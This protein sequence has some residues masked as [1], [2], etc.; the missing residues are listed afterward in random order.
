MSLSTLKFVQLQASEHVESVKAVANA[1]TFYATDMEISWPNISLPNF[2]RRVNESTSIAQFGAFKIAYGPLVSRTKRSEWEAF[3]Q[4]ETQGTVPSSILGFQSELGTFEPIPD[5]SS[6]KKEVK[7]LYAPLWQHAPM[8]QGGVSDVNFDLLSHP[9]FSEAIVSMLET[10][11]VVFSPVTTFAELS[12]FTDYSILDDKDSPQTI[13]L[14]PIHS[15]VDDKSIAGIA[16]SAISWDTL[17]SS[18]PNIFELQSVVVIRDSCG[19]VFTY[20]VNEEGPVFLG[21]GDHH[22][23]SYDHLEQSG[24]LVSVLDDA[25][26]D[27]VVSTNQCQYRVS[28]FPSSSLEESYKTN[29]R[30]ALTLY[31]VLGFVAVAVAF[32]LYDYFLQRRYWILARSAHRTDEIVA[33]FFP[34]TVRDRILDN[35]AHHDSKHDA[36]GKPIA[37]RVQLK[38]YLDDEEYDFS[39]A[40]HFVNSKPIADLFPDVTVMFA[41]I[42]GFTAWSSVR[43]PSQVFM[44][45]EH[46]YA[47]FDE[48]ARRRGVFKVETVGDCYVA[49]CGLPDPNPRHAVTMAR[50][51]R[52]CLHR[53]NDLTTHLEV[54]LGPDTGELELRVGLHSGPVTAGVL[55]GEK[56]RFQLFGDTMNTTSRIESTGQPNRIHISSDTADL[57]RKAGKEYWIK[58]REKTVEAKGKGIMSTYWL[59]SSPRTGTSVHSKDSDLDQDVPVSEVNSSIYTNNQNSKEDRLVSYISDVFLRLLREL[60]NRRD[61]LDRDN[62][63]RR[64]ANTEEILEHLESS[65]SREGT[66]VLD[67]VQDI[68]E[69]PNFNAI[70]DK[71]QKDPDS[72]VL[73]QKII[74]QVHHYVGT[75]AALYRK[76]AFHNFEHAAHVTMSTV[77]LL[78]RIVAPD[79]SASSGA[80]KSLHDHTYGIT[81][82]PLTRFA[83]VFSALI[84]DVDHLGIPNSQLIEENQVIAD[85][86]KNRSV[87]EQN[88]VDL[89]W[90]LL[91]R[92][93]YKDFRRTIY[94]TP[95][96]YDRFR[97]LVV[98]AVLATDI[99]DKELK[100]LRNGRW[101]KAFSDGP[102]KVKE[103]EKSSINRKATI[104]IEHL[105]QASDVSHTMQHWHVFTKWN[106]RLFHEMYTAYKQGRAVK[107][108]SEF[109][110]TGEMG[111]FD[112][113]IIPLAN[114]LKTCGVFGVS[115]DEYLTYA[116]KNRK[117]W[118]ARGREYVA[119]YLESYN[120]QVAAASNTEYLEMKSSSPKKSKT[121]F[122]TYGSSK[123]KEIA[124]VSSRKILEAQRSLEQ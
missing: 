26:I 72:V 15:R 73:P 34:K 62:P 10:G 67:E 24:D 105:I 21:T 61:A 107:D 59:E 17:F 56:A 37:P 11:R 39:H 86:Y 117:E 41:D 14:Q 53:M 122:N 99:M 30:I 91:M 68:I 63:N 71:Y 6:N 114:K 46:V 58:A 103:S 88:S 98:N 31:V 38:S 113:Y 74:S 111:F 18:A 44:L 35:A 93:E 2:E 89:A 70:A 108:P 27:Q 57:L 55:R 87:A 115:S 54:D 1:I 112:Y 47:D 119:S 23:S 50:F 65:G 7:K 90:N 104:V 102:A 3:V 52:D 4:D 29:G 94:S 60:T 48:I 36:T 116:I 33:S 28:V 25:E 96:G 77:K 85:I 109:W 106:E 49:A 9:V 8:S 83:V 51:A 64:P 16:I 32:L 43:E 118:E 100:E 92:D 45:L 42:A 66:M 69:L 81:T 80:D 20:Q 82:D 13:M 40:G 22:D 78:S 12:W 75:I 110:Y 121:P 95:S 97:K 19:D 123:L 84:H 79:I 101:D 120:E 5:E 124:E 76:N